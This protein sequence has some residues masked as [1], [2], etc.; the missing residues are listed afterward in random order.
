MKVAICAINTRFIHSSL[1]PWYLLSAL[2]ESEI[3]GLDALVLEGTIN[4]S[5]E[6]LTERLLKENAEVLAFSCYIWNIELV[7]KLVV[8]IKEK[9]PNIVIILGGPEVSY[10]PYAWLKKLPQ[11]EYILAG[12]GEEPFPKL[13]N[14]LQNGT[15]AKE[16]ISGLCY[17]NKDGGIVIS[18]PHIS[19]KNPPSPYSKEYFETLNSRITYIETSRG[20]PFSCTFCLSGKCTSVH[21]LP[22]ERCKKEL[23]LLAN[24]GTKTIK[25]VDRTFNCN[26]KRAKEI[27]SFL[28][29]EY[30]NNIPK[31]VCF[32][33]EMEG[34]LFD[35]EFFDILSK[36]PKGYFQM[37]I[38]I[39][40]FNEETLL[41]IK[42]SPS[43]SIIQESVH[44]ILQPRNIHLHIDLIAGLPFETYET[45]QTSFNKAYAL[46]ADMLQLGFLKVLSGTALYDE[47]ERDQ[48]NWKYTPT[49]PYEIIEN[50]WISKKELAELHIVEDTLERLYNSGRFKRTLEYVLKTAQISP[51]AFF[52]TFG[53]YLKENA[54]NFA[55]ISLD[56]YTEWVYSFCKSLSNISETVLRDNMVCDRL[57]SINTGKLPAVLH[58]QDKRL[59]QAAIALAEKHPLKAETKRGTSLLYGAKQVVYV[60]YTEKDPVT[61]HYKTNQIPAEE[62]GI[63]L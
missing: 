31:E 6:E 20:C 22:V 21:F 3:E 30:G 50:T 35:E 44:R 40:S 37:E 29:E 1:A 19:D 9:A 56:I 26:I 12:E 16:K 52:H 36:A 47:T 60:D 34:D 13:I 10:T 14:Y 18:P 61:G 46:Q 57:S 43:T 63:F 38:G 32:H 27:I 28:L 8:T 39:Q 59:K 54:E 23:V 51:F 15:G 41:A 2:N 55:G 17:R 4:Q 33:F 42:R 58:I 5:T 49:A 48:Y 11:V 62:L 7:L 25:L 53:V 24:S 45:F